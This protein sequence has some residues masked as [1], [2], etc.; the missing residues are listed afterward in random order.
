VIGIVGTVTLGVLALLCSDNGSFSG[1]C[2][3]R[4][5]IAL[6]AFMFT[7]WHGVALIV[8]GGVNYKGFWN[9]AAANT[10][11]YGVPVA[12]VVSLFFK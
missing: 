6:G 3:V 9:K 4:G 7:L 8:M 2:A 10:V 1:G 11:L 12:I 5:L